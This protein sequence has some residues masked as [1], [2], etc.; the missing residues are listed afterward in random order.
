M[1]ACLSVGVVGSLQLRAEVDVRR[2]AADLLDPEVLEAVDV[3]CEVVV[4]DDHLH[5]LEGGV[6]AV[7]GAVEV[8]HEDGGVRVG[9]GRLSGLGR[10][11]G[12][13]EASALTKPVRVP[14]DALTLQAAVEESLL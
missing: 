10:S 1:S 2:A 4:G 7:A 9:D 11:A 6:V 3:G 13:L 5:A 14:A 8:G 12:A